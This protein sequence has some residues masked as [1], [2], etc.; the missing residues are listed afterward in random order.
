MTE[1]TKNN[2]A[3][4]RIVGTGPEDGPALPGTTEDTPA[5]PGWLEPEVDV[6]FALL[7]LTGAGVERARDSYIDCLACVPRTM[8]LDVG[9]DA[10]RLGLLRA[11]KA[12]F[13][14]GDDVWRAFE[15]KLEAIESDLTSDL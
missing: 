13:T 3:P 8:D 6:A 4:V 12:E 2:E 14:L 7:G 5:A 10:C 15:Q 11:L 9:H 1:A